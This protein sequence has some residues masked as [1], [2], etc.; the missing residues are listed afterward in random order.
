L[1]KDILKSSLTYT[2]LGFLPLSFSLIFTPIYLMYLSENNYGILNLFMLFTGIISLIFNLGVSSAFGYL[3]WDVYKHKEKLKELIS[4]KLGLLVVFQIVFISLGLLFGESIVSTVIKSSDQ[5]T[6]NPIFILAL[7]FSAFM[8]FYEMFLYFFRNEDK[9]K[10]YATLSLSTLLL[11]TIGTFAGVV[12]LDMKEVGAIYGRTFSYGVVIVFFLAYFIYKYGI[13]FNISKSKVLL[14]FSIPL[15]INA[16]I[17]ALSYGADRIIIEQFD[18]LENLG[19]YGFALVIISVIETWFNA[20]NNTLSPTL[21]KFIKE[22]LVEKRREIKGLTHTIILLV[23]FFI[24]I[25]LDLLIPENFHRAATFV[26]ILAFGFLWRVFTSLT[27]YSLYIE[28][29]TKYLLYNQSSNLILTVVIGYF[30]YQVW[31]IMG[32]VVTIYIVRVI[33]YVIMNTI[34]RRVKELPFEFNKLIFL[35]ALLGLIGFVI[36]YLNLNSDC[37]IRY[38]L[39][40]TPL[41]A[42]LLSLPIFLKKEIK[43]LIYIF[44]QRK[45][46]F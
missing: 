8:V 10:L 35:S 23:I 33:E 28:K 20:L 40:A 19:V 44:K 22:S 21:Y 5:F 36:V 41:F 37:S 15:F 39:Y 17:G 25:M 12:L 2:I 38:L 13:N 43:N 1:A 46:L 14:A 24:T 6:Y 7:F 32:L 26:P 18:T 31:A 16:L 34:S 42:L 9:L 29:K 11:L 45:K 30:M 27:S 3:Y 4:S